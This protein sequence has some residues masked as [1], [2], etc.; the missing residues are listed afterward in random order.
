MYRI[1]TYSE[2]VDQIASLPNEAL[3]FY[4]QTLGVLE[5]V[6]WNGLPYNDAM[7]D[8]AMRQLVCGPGGAAVPLDDYDFGRDYR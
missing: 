7:P 8:G 1:E 3:A 6:P 2:A 5:L 4:A